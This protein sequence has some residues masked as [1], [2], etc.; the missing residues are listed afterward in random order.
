[1]KRSIG[2]QLSTVR[3]NFT[4][5]TG[6]LMGNIT[7]N[8][9]G[10][11]KDI[12]KSISKI[13]FERARKDLRKSTR[14]AVKRGNKMMNRG[15]KNFRKSDF[16]KTVNTIPDK[17]SRFSL[18]S[19]IQFRKMRKAIKSGY[20]KSKKWT[21]KKYPKVQAWVGD[22]TDAVKSWI[23]VQVPIVGSFIQ[24][25]YPRVEKFVFTKLPLYRAAFGR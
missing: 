2:K 6:Q 25:N 16:Y 11:A 20:F 13:D 1:M 5:E 3:K 4:K 19:L 14:I 24:G 7:K 9:S 15:M 17:A 18:W 21:L 12:S 8:T 10:I 23:S 22:T